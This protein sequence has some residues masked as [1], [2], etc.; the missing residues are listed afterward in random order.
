M[1][2]QWCGAGETAALVDGGV[3]G[4]FELVLLDA[5]PCIQKGEGFLSVPEGGWWKH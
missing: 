5:A 4:G 1:N 2:S 3:W